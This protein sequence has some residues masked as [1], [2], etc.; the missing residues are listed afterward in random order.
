MNYGNLIRDIGKYFMD[1]DTRRVIDFAESLSSDDCGSYIPVSV[2][3]KGII[4]KYQR[5]L[6]SQ[7]FDS[8]VKVGDTKMTK[9]EVTHYRLHISRK[10]L[11][12]LA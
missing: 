12:V 10:N 5:A 2:Q 8:S 1:E 3:S 4:L 7:G 6:K 11:E 9:G